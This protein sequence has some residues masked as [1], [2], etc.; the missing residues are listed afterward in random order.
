MMKSRSKKMETIC[1]RCRYSKPL[2]PSPPPPPTT[3]DIVRELE[4]GYV[5]LNDD[6]LFERDTLHHL[7]FQ[8]MMDI[9][10]S[11]VCVWFQQKLMFSRN[12]VLEYCQSLRC[13]NT[14]EDINVQNAWMV[15]ASLLKDRQSFHE[16]FH[17]DRRIAI[18][19]E[20]IRHRSRV[21]RIQYSFV[22]M[23]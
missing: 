19:D 8:F 21:T 5:F 9:D 6:M 14:I 4:I 16:T 22:K 3:V 12:L 13:P 17:V 7:C 1:L 15:L 2:P 18:M 11:F 23:V 10:I 20:E